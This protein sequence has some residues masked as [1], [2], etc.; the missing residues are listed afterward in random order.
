MRRVGFVGVLGTVLAILSACGSSAPSTPVPAAE[1]TATAR[2]YQATAT[3]SAEVAYL[4]KAPC[5]VGPEIRE[6]LR[7]VSDGLWDVG[8]SVRTDNASL[9]LQ[10]YEASIAYGLLADCRE[11]DATPGASP[12]AAGTPLAQAGATPVACIADAEAIGGL[13][14]AAAKGTAILFQLVFAGAEAEDLEPMA[15]LNGYLVQRAT[16]LEIACGLRPPGTPAPG[17]TP[18]P[19]APVSRAGLWAVA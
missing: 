2:V 7:V 17:A 13:R 14:D 12:V 18:L 3:A 6:A 5:L 1:R 19:P 9:G 10:Y 16:E 4:R 15:A 11:L 8:S